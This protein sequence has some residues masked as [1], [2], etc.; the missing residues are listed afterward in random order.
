MRY[1]LWR[2]FLSKDLLLSVLYFNWTIHHL[3]LFKC[4]MAIIIMKLFFFSETQTLGVPA[5][6]K[7]AF[8]SGPDKVKVV[9]VLQFRWSQG[10]QIKRIHWGCLSVTISILV[11]NNSGIYATQQGNSEISLVLNWAEFQL[12][13]TYCTYRGECRRKQEYGRY[14]EQCHMEDTQKPRWK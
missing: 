12:A 11:N 13:M 6:G 14:M 3:Y 10:E 1:I 9:Y 2:T 5:E 8:T 4:F 7:L